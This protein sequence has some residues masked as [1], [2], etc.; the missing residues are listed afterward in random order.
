MLAPKQYWL[1]RWRLPWRFLEFD[2]ANEGSDVVDGSIELLAFGFVEFDL[3][4]SLYASRAKDARN[5]Y[6]KPIYTEHPNT[7]T[8]TTA[9]SMAENAGETKADPVLSRPTTS[10]PAPLV[11]ST[12]A[13]IWASS[14]NWV[15]GTP[16][17]VQ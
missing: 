15:T 13:S 10:P 1:P 12:M 2:L 3:D 11:R 4:D 6:V 16:A 17:T 7:N 14:R 5:A 8:P 9:I